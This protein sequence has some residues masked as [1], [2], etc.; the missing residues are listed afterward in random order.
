MSKFKNDLTLTPMKFSIME[1]VE[2]RAGVLTIIEGESFAPGGY[3]R[4]KRFYSKKLWENVL[5]NDAVLEKLANRNMYGALGHDV[6][7]TEKSLR[8]GL[9]SHI[10]TDIRIDEN[11]KGISRYEV[12][13]TPSG[14]I[15]DSLARAGSSLYVS[16]RADGTYDGQDEDGNDIVSEDNFEFFTFDFVLDPGIKSANPKLVEM[17]EKLEEQ[18]NNSINNTGGN[19]ME[20]LQ[21]MLDKVM[22]EK[23]ILQNDLGDSKSKLQ[24]KNDSITILENKLSE[25][26]SKLKELEEKLVKLT[27]SDKLL[28]EFNKLDATPSE[29]LEANRKAAD[30]IKSYR[31]VASS[32]RVVLEANRKAADLIKSYRGIGS[33]K[34]IRETNKK[35][36]VLIS[37]Y[38]KLGTP[39]Q[40]SRLVSETTT[41]KNELRLSALVSDLGVS[42]EK[43]K[44]FGLD[45][46]DKEIKEFFK[47]LMES[48]FERTK[49]VKT[50]NK[51]NEDNKSDD[52]FLS[53]SRA[54]R[55]MQ[56]F[57]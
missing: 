24:E 20:K 45:K 39:S 13:D 4:N 7:L 23:L 3:S 32:P 47:G 42:E 53:G 27:E 31:N 16:S 37:E 46:S 15:L 54:E 40:I 10:V 30:L 35:A 17:L 33:V 5:G 56:S 28:E 14:R 18:Y 55:L 22:G 44:Q 9:F 2:K 34:E 48:N 8:E 19:G 11:G 29:I 49:Y 52:N 51:L 1:G 43:I 57:R 6:E 21:E 25:S 50:N 38:K 36:H 26:D 12:L 41:K